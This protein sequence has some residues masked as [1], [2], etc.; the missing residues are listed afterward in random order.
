[1][2]LNIFNFYLKIV[3]YKLNSKISCIKDNLG[4]STSE[5]SSNKYQ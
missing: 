3:N 5:I 1:M 2:M 4:E